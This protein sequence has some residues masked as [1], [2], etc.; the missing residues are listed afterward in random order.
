[1][2]H[3]RGL[4]IYQFLGPALLTPASLWLWW[5][6]SGGHWPLTLLAWG[7]PIAW[8]YL[9]PAVGTNLL[10]VWE[11]DVRLRWGRFRPHHGFVLGSASSILAA[12]VHAAPAGNL[13][14]A[15][16]YT[17]V[18]ACVLGWINLL[19]DVK[20]LECGLLRVYNQPWAEGKG[21]EAVAMDYAPWFFGGFGAAYGLSLGLLEWLWPDLP[22]HQLGTAFACALGFTI[23]VPVMGYITRSRRLHGHWGTRP[24]L[25]K[26]L[27]ES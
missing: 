24:V 5:R 13:L 16:R 22:A 14:E 6:E 17:L 8:A 11:F 27:N 26:E 10:K 9:V 18:L 25:A 3:R 19:Y 2:G 20:A 7:V 23:L 1:M 15:L 4:E 12:L 21:P